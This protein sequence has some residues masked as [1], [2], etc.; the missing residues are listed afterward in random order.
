MS[1]RVSKELSASA[2]SL[3]ESREFFIEAYIN[4]W[5]LIIIVY[6]D[7]ALACMFTYWLVKNNSWQSHLWGLRFNLSSWITRLKSFIALSPVANFIKL[8]LGIINTAIGILPQ[9]LSWVMPLVNY[10]EKSF[11]KLTPGLFSDPSHILGSML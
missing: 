1:N 9:V 3:S 8:F 6:S 11:M 2:K 10:A 7:S 4:N 5:C